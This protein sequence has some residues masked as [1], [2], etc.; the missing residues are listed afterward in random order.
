[1]LVMTNEKDKQKEE[2]GGVGE[3]LK[4]VGQ[5]IVGEIETLGGILTADPLT[6]AEGEFNVE[7]GTLRRENSEA[8]D[9]IE[10]A[11]EA[12]NSSQIE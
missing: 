6:Q 4:G 7:A 9:E 11:D 2:E 5:I 10:K 1:M 8:P 12:K 3:K